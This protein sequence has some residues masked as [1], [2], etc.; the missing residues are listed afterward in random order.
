VYAW[1]V[2]EQV[3]DLRNA[4]Q[5][6]SAISRITGV[7]RYAARSWSNGNMPSSANWPRRDACAICRQSPEQLPAGPYSYLLGL[8]LGDGC[9]SERPR[10]VYQLRITCCTA[11]PS[12]MDECEMAMTEVLPN[13]VCRVVRV[14]CTELSSGSK[15]WIC[16]FPQHGR[17]RK[18]L[19]RIELVDWQLGIVDRFPA[20]FLR[21]LI[22]SDGCRVLNWVN[23]TPYPRYHFSNASA[24][25]RA[26]FG[27]ACDLL[28]VDW[29][30]NNARN[31][32]VARRD[33]VKKLDEFV[34][35]KR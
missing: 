14:G 9:I 27:Y 30:P 5:N 4:G 15:H 13:R 21:G 31:L 6:F 25:I 12:L 18:H 35:P 19:R 33:S 2:V 17:G 22:H 10:G 32:S 1:E 28:G 29:R 16:H 26:L 7:S 20:P 34:G 3:L 8:Y 24:D 11:Y 23:G